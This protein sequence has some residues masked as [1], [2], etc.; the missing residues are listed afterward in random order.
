[1]RQPSEPNHEA[2]VEAGVVAPHLQR[3]LTPD[4]FAQYAN[5]NFRDPA[6]GLLDRLK[7]IAPSVWTMILSEALLVATKHSDWAA[8]CPVQRS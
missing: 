5:G 2:I 7:T 1:M 3:Y 4:E 8:A 6:I